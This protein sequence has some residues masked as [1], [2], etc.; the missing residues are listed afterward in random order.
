MNISEVIF[1]RRSVRSYNDKEVSLEKLE[2]V[3]KAAQAAPSASNKQD[4]KLIVVKDPEKRRAL[5]QAASNQEFVGEAPIIIVPVSLEPDKVMTCEVPTYAVDL[6]IAVDH[7]TLAAVEEGLGTCWIGAFSQKEVK[8][9][10]GI[11][12]SYKVLT[13]LPLGY[14]ADSP[15]PKT[16]K[17]LQELIS[18]DKF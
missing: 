9:I 10:L 17:G 1:T 6:A 7:M 2:K 12:E 14:P 4:Y 11:P 16:R 15:R 13:L 8:M 18:Y 5:A 3:L